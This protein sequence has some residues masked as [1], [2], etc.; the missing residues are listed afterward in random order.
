MAKKSNTVSIAESVTKEIDDSLA[1]LQ[2]EGEKFEAE[3]KNI[4]PS[5]IF[6]TANFYGTR[7]DWNVWGDF[8]SHKEAHDAGF[9]WSKTFKNEPTIIKKTNAVKN[10]WR[11]IVSV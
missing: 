7:E 2:K 3:T 10:F 8:T 5:C 9:K 1:L 6:A 4:F 11:V